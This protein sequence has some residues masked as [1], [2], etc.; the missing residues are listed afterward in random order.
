MRS[1]EELG[2]VSIA[3]DITKDEDIVSVVKRI[4]A[5]HGAIDILIDNAGHGS[6]EAI[7]EV[8]IDEARRQFEVNLFGVAR[9]TQ[10][11]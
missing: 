11:G 1:L 10:S 6:N 8:P 3:M 4:T 9:L 7:E 2:A 5:D